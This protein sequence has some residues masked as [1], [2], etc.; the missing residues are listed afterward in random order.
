[1]EQYELKKK[2]YRLKDGSFLNISLDAGT[3]STYA[4]VKGLDVF[5]EVIETLRRYKYAGSYMLLKYIILPENCNKNDFDGFVKLA[6]ELRPISVSVSCDI[7]IKAI[8]LPKKIIDGAVYLAGELKSHNITT[9]I[10]PYF[11][12]DN[13]NYIKEKMEK[14]KDGKTIGINCNTSI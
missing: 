9:T 8:D 6:Q 7:R 2:Y 10:M 3:K 5:E 13:T 14:Q 4:A 11:G 1:M 12:E